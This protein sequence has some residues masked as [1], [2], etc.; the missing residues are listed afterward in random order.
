MNHTE[1]EYSNTRLQGA[2]RPARPLPFAADAGYR[3][4]SCRGE[5]IEQHWFA[6]RIKDALFL[7][8]VRPNPSLSP[9]P[10]TAGQLARAARWLMLHRAGKPS[11]LRGRG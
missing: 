1:K 2:E 8:K 4:C 6:P 3:D 9:R 10:A 11:R 7:R 5:E